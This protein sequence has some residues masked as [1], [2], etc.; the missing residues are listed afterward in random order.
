MQFASTNMY[1][2]IDIPQISLGLLNGMVKSD[3]PNEK[4]HAQ[5][6]KRQMLFG[7]DT[8]RNWEIISTTLLVADVVWAMVGVQ[9]RPM[10]E[11]NILEELLCSANNRTTEQQTIGSLL[12]KVKNSKEWDIIK[13]PSERAERNPEIEDRGLQQKSNGT[14]EQASSVDVVLVKDEGNSI[15]DERGQVLQTAQ[16]AMNMLDMTMPGTLTE[17]QKQKYWYCEHSKLLRL[18]NKE[19]FPRF[20]KWNIGKMY[21]K[22]KHISLVDFEKT[23]EEEEEADEQQDNEEEEKEKGNEQEDIDEEEGQ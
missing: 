8:P 5:W 23:E 12:T 19:G 20:M 15:D 21:S 17:E 18:S 11:V 13:S 3:F 1:E 9:A 2:R 10:I 14:L 7:I 6:K 4:S 16:V 22:W